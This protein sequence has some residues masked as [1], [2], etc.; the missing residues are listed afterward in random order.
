MLGFAVG[1]LIF[2][3]LCE[4][5]GRQVVF[6]VT[7]GA[8]A[9]LNAGAAVAP[10]IQSLLVIRFFA[11]AFGSSPLT[12]AGG[13]I[14][15]MY[16]PNLVGL[17]MSLFIIAPFIGPAVGPISGGFI[18]D[19]GGWRWVERFL[20]LLTGVIWLLGCV[21]V[22]ETYAPTLLKKRAE[23][24]S[25]KTG[26][27]YKSRLEVEKGGKSVKEVFSKALGRPWLL[28]FMEPIVLLLAVY[29][30]IVYGMCRKASRTPFPIFSLNE[31]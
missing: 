17:A 15:D 24:L 9:V 2:G 1:P 27:I 3:P 20:A 31:S 6:V 8:L 4:L 25:S 28:L 23:K 19:T 21:V 11:G 14:A 5:Y 12:N 30:A 29:M 10:N 26:K 22:P 13:Q 18:A 7:Y 16:G